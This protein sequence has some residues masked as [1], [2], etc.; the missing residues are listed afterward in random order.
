MIKLR[1][2]ILSKKIFCSSTSALKSLLQAQGILFSIFWVDNV[3]LES[4]IFK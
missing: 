2:N 4:E 3:K 1:V